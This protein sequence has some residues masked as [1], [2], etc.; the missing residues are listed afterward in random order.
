MLRIL[1]L[2]TVFIMISITA[3]TQKITGNIIDSNKQA[4]EFATISLINPKDSTL[5]SYASSNS[6]GDFEI[7][8]VENGN[9][10]FQI[11]YIGLKEFSRSLEFKGEP[12]K[13]GSII[14]ENT[15]ELDEIVVSAN[16]PIVLKEDTIAYNSKAFKIRVDD[17]VEDLLK[18]LPGV[19]VDANGKVTAQGESVS[20]IYVN[21]KEFF[22]NDPTIATK[23]LSADAIES[24]EI[25]DEKS[26]NA[27][28]SGI[29]DTETKKVI[30]LKLKDENKV[31]DF[32][33]IQGGYGTHDRFAASLNYSRF[34]TKTQL[35][36]IGKY[37][38]IN[39]FGSNITDISNISPKTSGFTTT[40][41]AGINLS[42]EIKEKKNVGADYFYNNSN[43]T[44]GDVFTSRTEFIGDQEIKSEIR[45][46]NENI[47]S[48]ND[49]NFNF[50]DR[51][52][53]LSSLTMW[54]SVTNSK[55]STSNLN[56]LDKY[57]GKEELDLQSIGKSNG[58]SKSNSASITSYYTKRF[59]EESKRNLFLMADINYSDKESI[60]NN[61]QL[62]K[63]NISDPSNSFTSK[64]EITRDKDSDNLY[65]SLITDYT[66]PLA[67][68]HFISIGGGI[69]FDYK[70]ENVDQL[71]IENDIN[72]AS[73]I[74]S[75]F[76]EVRSIYGGL[77]YKYNKNKFTFITGARLYNKNQF[78]GIK[79]D[80]Y[81]KNYTFV[82]PTMRIRYR[83]K[84]G[85]HMMLRINKSIRLPNISQ[86]SPVENN[87]DPLYIKKG[88]PD[89]TPSERYRASAWYSKHFFSKELNLS[90]SFSYTYTENNIVNTEFTDIYGVRT[91]SYKNSGDKNNVSLR[92][93][94]GKTVKSIN[95]RYNIN[96]RGGY[97]EY[98][99]IINNLENETRSKNL[100]LELSL[101]NDKKEVVD[102]MIGAKF[103]KDYTTFTSGNNA[104]REYFK[105][106]YFVNI[107]YNITDRLNFNSQFK[108]D[109]YTDSNFDSDQS[110]PIW[111]GSISYK[112]L[113]SKS[114]NASFS[115]LDILNKSLGIIRNSSDNYFEETQKD[116]L[117]NYYMVSLIYQLGS[118]K[119]PSR[120]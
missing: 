113:K 89:L 5:V 62:N 74:Y 72:M 100:G 119:K 53:K 75:Q 70:N 67:E 111:N 96:L 44:S 38:N 86:L 10:T 32:G 42:Y 91:S 65:L 73:L 64:Q 34:S 27:R 109:I 41:I 7:T 61:N 88:N 69:G 51:S 26:D 30:N 23:N 8:N 94:L 117:G 95:L 55:S 1:A 81:N 76:Y 45:S 56:T 93:N 33:K 84:K 2:T 20:K 68:N 118:G 85:T 90:T 24:I 97:N 102:M 31:N 99:S 39:S 78:F 71:N 54:G 18:K 49:L 82:N 46:K 79:T 103:N 11:N 98:L 25:I 110:F 29:N 6:K 4:V 77:K 120:K 40:G 22:G 101:E 63:F 87:Y 48:S 66:E 17:N 16:I 112:L 50:I 9:Y 3:W 104:D 37:N 19:E 28:V 60:N 15:N 35:S 59:S 52:D 92:F 116:V 58:K 105:Q 13:F 47:N 57:N 108:Y 83:P 80:K 107:D 115:A 114:L 14:L 43:T 12:I 36:I 106:S 21:G